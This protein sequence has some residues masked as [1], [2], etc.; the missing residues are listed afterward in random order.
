MCVKK[1]KKHG[2]KTIIIKLKRKL[3]ISADEKTATN[4]TE[5]HNHTVND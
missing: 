4:F 5:L 2:K 3:Q 1:M